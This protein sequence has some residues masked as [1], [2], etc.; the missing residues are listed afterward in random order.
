MINCFET[1]IFFFSIFTHVKFV[2]SFFNDETQFPSFL[3]MQLMSAF[4]CNKK[5]QFFFSVN[6]KKLKIPTT[7]T[8]F[9]SPFNTEELE[10]KYPYLSSN[11]LP[12]IAGA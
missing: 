4:I 11:Y 5:T 12:L 8:K 10:I 6:N 3:K 9:N 7:S 2:K 1:F